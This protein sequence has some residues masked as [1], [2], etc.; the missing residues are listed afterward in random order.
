MIALGRRPASVSARIEDVDG[1]RAQFR[2]AQ[3]VRLR[4]FLEPDLLQFI[5]LHIA[6]GQFAERTHGSGGAAWAREAQM[7]PNPA[8]SLLYFLANDPSVFHAVRS[9]TGCGRIGCFVGRVYRMRPDPGHY[10]WWHSDAVD[11]RLIGMSLNVGTDVYEGGLFQMRDGASKHVLSDVVNTTPGDAFLF[12]LDPGL[13][14]RV[15]AVEGAIDKVAFAGWF[16]SEPAFASLLRSP[17]EP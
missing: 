14:H 4:H 12:R 15:S 10:D 16:S 9:I 5:Q 3:W 8:L 6:N 11:H 17:L 1:L 13:E 2:V 7:Q